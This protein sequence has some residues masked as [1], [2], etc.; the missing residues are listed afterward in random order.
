MTRHRPEVAAERAR[1]ARVDEDQVL[2]NDAALDPTDDSL[3]ARIVRQVAD[4][5]RDHRDAAARR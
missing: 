4:D 3:H 5:I 2:T 1:L